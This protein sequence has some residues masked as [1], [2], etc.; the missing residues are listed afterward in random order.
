MSRYV[1]MD[2][3]WDAKADDYLAK[4]VHD[5]EPI[6][7]GLYDSTGKKIYKVMDR[8]GFIHPKD[9]DL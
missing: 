8:I 7:T 1:T 2:R 5:R 4:T 3:D 6:D 9:S